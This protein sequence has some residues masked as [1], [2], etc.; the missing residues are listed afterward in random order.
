MS[1]L[2][3]RTGLERGVEI[4]SLAWALDFPGTFAY[5]KDDTAA[6][7]KLPEALIEYQRWIGLHSDTNWVN[8]AKFELQVVESFDT[9]FI[10]ENFTVNAFFEDDRRSLR[11]VEIERAL[12]IHTWQRQEL[13]ASVNMLGPEVMTL[14]LPGQRWNINGILNHVGQ[15]ELWYLSNLDLPLPTAEFL[16]HNPF[17]ILEVS[18]GLVQKLLPQLEGNSAVLDQGGELWSARKLVRRLLWHQRDHIEHIQQIVGM[19]TR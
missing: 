17:K 1:F 9:Y 14:M 3:V 10:D 13:F 6:L 11:A 5:G 15:V 18:F 2:Q 12:K 19:A 4:R 7:D 8:L 16:V